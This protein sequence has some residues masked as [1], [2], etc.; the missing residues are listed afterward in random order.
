MEAVEKLKRDVAATVGHRHTALVDDSAARLLPFIEPDEWFGAKLTDDVQQ[1][2]HDTFID[3]TW[4]S[5]PD[6]GSH[7]LWLTEELMWTC[8]STG[9]SVCR[10]GQLADFV[11]VDDERARRN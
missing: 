5:C 7:P 1:E 11:S 3:T 10:L 4:P 2:I 9:R 8:Q 6:H